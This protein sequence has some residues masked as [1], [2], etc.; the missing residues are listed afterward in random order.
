MCIGMLLHGKNVFA[1]KVYILTV[2][3][4]HYY[5]PNVIKACVIINAVVVVNDCYFNSNLHSHVANCSLAYP[6][7]GAFIS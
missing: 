7:I 2:K 4:M 3:H 6:I 5:L 1:L